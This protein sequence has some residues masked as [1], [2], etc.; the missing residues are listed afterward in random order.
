MQLVADL[1]LTRAIRPQICSVL[2]GFHEFIPHS[3]VSL[4]DEYELVSSCFVSHKPVSL[5]GQ[6]I[7]MMRL[8]R[9]SINTAISKVLRHFQELLMSGLPEVDMN[10]WEKNTTYANGYDVE[11]PVIVVSKYEYSQVKT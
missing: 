7:C 1:K 4:F 8:E 3:L 9:F 2:D 5:L 10:D 6:M 11:S